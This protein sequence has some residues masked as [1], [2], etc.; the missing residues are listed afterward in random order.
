[1]NG[2]ELYA[3]YVSAHGGETGVRGANELITINLKE[4]F[5]GEEGI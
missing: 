4:N 1:M 2:R 5:D 3:L